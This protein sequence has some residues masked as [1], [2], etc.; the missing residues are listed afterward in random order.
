VTSD[1]SVLHY[2]S[3]QRLG[4]TVSPVCDQCASASERHALGQLLEITADYHGESMI[5]RVIAK[6]RQNDILQLHVD[7]RRL[8]APTSLCIT[9][10]QME[11][12]R[13]A[14]RDPCKTTSERYPCFC[15]VSPLQVRDETAVA[16]LNMDSEERAGSSKDFWAARHV[17]CRSD[18][19]VQ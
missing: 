14:T 7:Q 18:P 3:S 19:Q 17:M 12:A 16:M 2:I 1:P 6:A 10:R 13:S 8:A 5:M 11:E 4:I 9:R 15:S